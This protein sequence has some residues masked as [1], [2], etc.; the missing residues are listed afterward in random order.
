MNLPTTQS[1]LT[2]SALSCSYGIYFLWKD[3]IK[4]L[5]SKTG[6]W[7]I[8]LAITDFT[9]TFLT[10]KAYQYTSL[11][12]VQL[13]DCFSIPT[14]M[15]LTYVIFKYKFKRLHYV[16]VASC[17]IGVGMLIASDSHKDDTWKGNLLVIAGAFLYGVNNV[18]LEWLAKFIGPYKYLGTYCWFGLMIS[19][20]QMVILERDNLTKAPWDN[21]MLYLSLIGFVVFLFT[22]LTVMPIIM[23]RYSAT[24]ANLNLMAADIYSAFAGHFIFSVSFSFLYIIAIFFILG[25]VL[26]YTYQNHEA[27]SCAVEPEGV[28]E[29]HSSLIINK[30]VEAGDIEQ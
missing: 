8:F 18:C 2:Y 10:V 3:G 17:I 4:H 30:I 6:L 14:I 21:Y 28:K 20:I 19:C 16:G 11:V 7:C 5:F 9:A 15:V 23:V 26:L 1:F 12:S 13:L 25:G 22:F 29:E 27:N 24:F